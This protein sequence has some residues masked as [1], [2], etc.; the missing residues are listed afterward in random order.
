MP[1]KTIKVDFIRLQDSAEYAGFAGLL[2]CNLCDTINVVFPE[3][4]M[5]GRFKIVKTTYDVL[6]D[7][8]TEMELGAL[9]TTL[10]EALGISNTL[11]RSSGSGGGSSF[12]N[13]YVEN[14]LTVDGDF[15][16]GGHTTPVGTVNSFT[17]TSTTTVGTTVVTLGSITL[18]PGSWVARGWV[19]F[20]AGTTGYR[21]IWV[22]NNNAITGTQTGTCTAIDS[23]LQVVVQ[24]VGLFSS[25]ESRTL[26]LRAQ[27][28]TSLTVTAADCGLSIMRI[29]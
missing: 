2:Q 4:N 26:Y 21:R 13:L 23:A 15:Y 22:T 17:R 9:S 18:P 14:T 5:E 10:A 1:T 24:N 20:P 29:A 28:S 11:D 19:R 27:A 7:K 25:E 16:L 8:Y 6:E 3:Y 12:D